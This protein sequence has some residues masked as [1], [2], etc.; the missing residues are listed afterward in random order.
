[1]LDRSLR[2][3]LAR[4]RDVA[5]QYMRTT[6]VSQASGQI[7]PVFPVLLC[8]PK[9]VAGEMSLGEV[10]QAASAFVLVQQAFSWLVD[11]YPRFADWTA[12]ARRVASL[13]VSLDNLDRAEEAGVGY[14]ERGETDG[15]ALRLNDLSVTLDDG[16]MVVKDAEVAI[17]PGEKVLVVG[18]SGTGKS[19]LVRAIAGLWPWGGG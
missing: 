6:M 2:N 15:A 10:M 18:E 19:S 7:A 17:A 4:W 9:Y 11:N 12:S 8:A 1:Q 13:L 16:T 14:I 3:V 5:V